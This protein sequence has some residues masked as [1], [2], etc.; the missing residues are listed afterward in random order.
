VPDG[1]DLVL[2]SV[3][4]TW[5]DSLRSLRK[6]GRLVVFGGTG[7]PMVE[8]DVRYLYLNYLSILGTTGASPREF[9]RFLETVQ[10]GSRSPAI[11]S[12]RPLAEA[13]SGYER[14]QADH[15]GKIVL[16]IG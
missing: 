14:L 15:Y 5:A 2:D 6:G 16:S 8:L 12:I 13:E 11:D 3:G 4:T 7:G 10:D 9:G 1:V